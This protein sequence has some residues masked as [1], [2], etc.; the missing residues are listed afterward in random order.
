MLIEYT[1][2]EI[3]ADENWQAAF[4]C[5]YCSELIDQ[6]DTVF[7]SHMEV[8]LVDCGVWGTADCLL[9]C[10]LTDGRYLK[11]FASDT[12][13]CDGCSPFSAYDPSGNIEF[14][15]SLDEL[16]SPNTLTQ[17]EAMTIGID[18]LPSM[19]PNRTDCP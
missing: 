6:I 16:L 13:S 10:R 18:W 1:K 12:L 7:A 9:L 2:K 19:P 4:R 15:N 17:S 5:A 3:Q 11:L 14:Y 8:N